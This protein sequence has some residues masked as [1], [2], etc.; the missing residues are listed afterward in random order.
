MGGFGALNWSVLDRV[1][2]EESS[3]GTGLQH[4]ASAAKP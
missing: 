1:L 3:L 2:E 4:A